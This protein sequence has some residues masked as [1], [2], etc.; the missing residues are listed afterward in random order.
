MLQFSPRPLPS[1]LHSSPHALIAIRGVSVA[2]EMPHRI[3]LA[4]LLHF[5]PIFY[6]WVLPPLERVG[7]GYVGINILRP[8]NTQ[9]LNAIISRMCQQA[10]LLLPS[11]DFVVNPTILQSIRI[12]QAWEALELPVEGIEGLEIHLISRLSFG[13]AV[14]GADLRV[15]WET[16]P[17]T[18]NIMCEAASNFIRSHLEDAYGTTTYAGIQDWIRQDRSRMQFFREA[19]KQHL[20]QE[21]ESSIASGVDKDKGK[22]VPTSG[23]EVALSKEA[24]VK[25]SAHEVITRRRTLRL[26][27]EERNRRLQK[28]RTDLQHRLRRIRSDET[29]RSVDIEPEPEANTDDEGEDAHSVSSEHPVGADSSNDSAKQNSMLACDI[30]TEVL[31]QTLQGLI[32]VD[33]RPIVD[34]ESH[35]S[36]LDP[37]IETDTAYE[38]EQER[39]SEARSVRREARRKE[40]RSH[41]PRVADSFVAGMLAEGF[42]KG[43]VQRGGQRS[44]CRSEQ[45]AT[46][47]GVAPTVAREADQ[48]LN[49]KADDFNLTQR[50]HALALAAALEAVSFSSEADSQQ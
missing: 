1:D 4:M 19:H 44:I 50:R 29:L 45:D 38:L 6:R 5:A 46:T 9:G 39:L 25:S 24:V 30:G 7:A 47:Q 16:F 2:E 14:T 18:S 43:K 10:G 48:Q 49:A 20:Q 34:R 35:A 28:D 23:K 31:A 36:P 12:M 17:T 15:I 33:G 26:S 21:K 11:S 37:E 32:V 13:E 41:A 40:R 3:P 22:T 8:I 27:Q 42:G